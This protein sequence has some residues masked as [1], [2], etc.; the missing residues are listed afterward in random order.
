MSEAKKS[1]EGALPGEAELMDRLLAGCQSPEDILGPG[2][3]FNRPRKRLIERLLD[4]E[5]SS[6]L[7][8]RGQKPAAI[9]AMATVPRRF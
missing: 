6:H 9:T 8:S 7:G 5:L 2:G 3:A 1:V 4:T